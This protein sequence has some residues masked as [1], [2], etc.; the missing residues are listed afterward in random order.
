MRAQ[1]ALILLVWLLLP[2]SG[3]VLRGE[4]TPPGTPEAKPG[5]TAAG[6]VAL[7]PEA[8]TLLAAFK[9]SRPVRVEA[10]VS[11]EVPG[12]CVAVRAA[13][14]ATL[15]GIQAAAGEKVRV[16]IHETEWLSDEAARAEEL[17]GIKPWAMTTPTRTGS[18]TDNIYLSVAVRS[19]AGLVRL[20]LL[21][22][23]T[24]PEYELVRT[25]C[26][27]AGP[28][29]RIGVVR[30]DANLFGDAKAGSP[31]WPLVDELEAQYEVASVDAS[32][33]I[34]ERYDVL[35]A[36]QPS[37]L[38]PEA[39]D[40][41]VE[42]VRA[43]Q[44]TAIFEDPCPRLAPEIAATS[45][46]RTP[47]GG[48]NP[49]MTMTAA[50]P[51]PKGEV[52]RLWDLLGIECPPDV[53]VWQD[54]NPYARIDLFREQKEFVFVGKGS[55]AAEPFD[56]EN[57]IT[58]GLQN[59]LFPY[60]GAIAHLRSSPLKFAALARTG[61]RTG[62]A[63]YSDLFT[64]SPFGPPKLNPDPRLRVT[65]ETYVL[66]AEVRGKPEPDQP[67]VHAVV[68]ADVDMLAPTLFALREQGMTAELGINFDF[69]NVPL[70]LNAV[71]VL[72]GDTRFLE[73]RRRAAIRPPDT[74]T[75]A[76]IERD[77]K[78]AD[79]RARIQKEYNEALAREQEALDKQLRDL[80][81]RKDLSQA[82]KAAQIG[83]LAH[84]GQRRTKSAIA[85][86]EKRR[87]EE[88]RRL[89]R[90][91]AR[92]GA[93]QV[94][95]P[96]DAPGTRLGLEEFDPAAV[97]RLEFLSG[98]ETSSKPLPFEVAL[99]GEGWV[100][101]SH[102]DYPVGN[103][104]RVRA[105]ADALARLTIAAV[106]EEAAKDFGRYGLVEPD[107]PSY[108][109][110]T[111]RGTR[112][113]L[114]SKD[115]RLLLALIVGHEVPDK[116]GTRYVRRPYEDAVYTAAL[117]RDLLSTRLAD[118]HEKNPLQIDAGDVQRVEIDDYSVDLGK[119]SLDQ[120]G[121]MT[122]ERRTGGKPGWALVK[123]MVQTRG[124]LKP[125]G[126][127]D[128]GQVNAAAIDAMLAALAD[129]KLADVAPKPPDLA[130]GLKAG[131][132]P[133]DN[134]EAITAMAQRGFFAARLADRVQLI[135]VEG[136][137]RLAVV[138]GVEVLLR[139]GTASP[140]GRFLF[141]T[142]EFREAAVPKSEKAEDREAAVD[143]GKKRA[144]EL[145]ERFAGW[146]Y[147]IPDEVYRKIRLGRGDIVTKAAP[148]PK[149]VK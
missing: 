61:N 129:L 40:H 56:R 116:P 34:K 11:P 105:V 100:L 42:A 123:D 25:I 12:P 35:L 127:E 104:G 51:L 110:D 37:T 92:P 2:V 121:Q 122:I 82:E 103:R 6:A 47:P 90:R 15:R 115:G 102:D 32:Q 75:A 112:V 118:W 94:R 88:L 48:A 76:E 52:Q 46:P 95:E 99:T 143:R 39:M 74:R 131:K 4:G 109:A 73:L 10:F 128:S 63:R 23:G 57:P 81:D 133:L 14:L 89:E 135:S 16:F 77:E 53:V 78:L 3:A 17:Y 119:S 140:Q 5:E 106:A 43:G 41:L 80:Q 145:S 149:P 67:E 66:A 22:P 97:A 111:A 55:G 72:S 91:P 86:L 8:R 83:I 69:D 96:A 54:Y 20:P 44:P 108:A 138:D 60:P 124:G 98:D 9:P 1:A 71:D 62:T 125:A 132:L 84:E 13:L 58:R 28:R 146:Y 30:T 101:A 144:A 85:Q 7:S 117:P 70:V 79:A 50:K 93:V 26:A 29:K 136:E 31:R 142:A 38:P 64:P 114:R 137:L 87:D 24:S 126:A 33:P 120:R 113:T 134:R 18:R 147:V 27:S 21:A 59:A 19:P 141:V 148:A 36:V 130:A 107:S 45:Q 49:M 139:F 65:K 68:V